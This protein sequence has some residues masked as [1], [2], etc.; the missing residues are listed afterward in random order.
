VVSRLHSAECAHTY[1]EAAST[2]E[3]RCGDRWTGTSCG[4]SLQ[5]PARFRWSIAVSSSKACAWLRR[6]KTICNL[7]AAR[8][9]LDHLSPT[10]F[11]HPRDLDLRLK[12]GVSHVLV[13][14]NVYVVLHTC[15][16]ENAYSL[17]PILLFANTDVSI[18]KMCLDTSILAKSIMG[19]RKYFFFFWCICMY[20]LVRCEGHVVSPILLLNY[21]Y[22]NIF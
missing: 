9:V 4:A 19:W 18:T 20:S 11:R 8:C 1:T 12:D 17:W 13:R 21:M 15:E 6:R 16:C 3:W 10:F 7:L 2:T 14:T 5:V 22:L